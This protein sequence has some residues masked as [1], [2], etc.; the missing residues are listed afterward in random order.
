MEGGDSGTNSG[1]LRPRKAKPEE[2]QQPPSGKRP[3]EA[4]RND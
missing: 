2:A 3:P 1:K 4:Q